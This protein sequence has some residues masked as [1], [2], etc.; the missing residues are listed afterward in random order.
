LRVMASP[1]WGVVGAVLGFDSGLPPGHTPA[2]PAPSRLG[3]EVFALPADAEPT[4]LLGPVNQGSARCH[5]S[6]RGLEGVRDHGAARGVGL[7]Q[8]LAPS[9][10]LRADRRRVTWIMVGMRRVDQL[11]ESAEMLTPAVPIRRDRAV[12]TVF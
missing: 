7:S 3:V 11:A 6:N 1:P 10:A 4:F 12:D 8:R 9:L 2:D 5:E